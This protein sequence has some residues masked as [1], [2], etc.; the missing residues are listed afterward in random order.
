MEDEKPFAVRF[1]EDVLT[2]IKQAAHEERRSINYE[3]VWA[4]SVYLENRKQQQGQVAVP[5]DET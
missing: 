5:K 3:I 2:E 1:P 4:V